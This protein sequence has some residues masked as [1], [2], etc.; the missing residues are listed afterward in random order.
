ME[1]IGQFWRALAGLV[2]L[3][4][5]SSCEL[6]EEAALGPVLLPADEAIAE[7]LYA[8]APRTPVGFASDP[9]PPSF[10]QVTTY[11][12]KSQQL[13]AAATQHEVCTDEWNEAL[14]WSEMLAAQAP[15]YLDLVGNGTTDSYFEFDRVP[16]GQPE[17]YV[18]MRVYRCDYVDRTGVD[19]AAPGAFA[20]TFNRRPLDGEGLRALGEYLWLFTPYNNAGNAALASEVHSGPPLAHEIVLASL[21]PA[22]AGETCDRVTLRSWTHTVDGTT[23]VLT[24]TTALVREFLVRREAGVPVG[25]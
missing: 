18:R 4:G 10:T 19:L 7:Q 25:C 22:G 1:R 12:V 16:R 14:A 21:T 8:G 15:E 9:A 5:M 20:G 3:A 6:P 17:R 2:A 13:G 23:G 24:L 11:H